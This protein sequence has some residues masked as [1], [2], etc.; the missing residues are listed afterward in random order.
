LSCPPPM[1]CATSSAKR[2]VRLRSIAS[3][4]NPP[5]GGENPPS[6]RC[7]QEGITLSGDEG[8]RLRFVRQAHAEGRAAAE[9]AL[10][11]DVAAEEVEQA[12]DGVEAEADAAVAACRRA[13]SLAER[14]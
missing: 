5:E 2:A 9:L 7:T 3:A 14:L 11:G 13:V 10:D 4:W 6:E 12:A 8:L 1:P